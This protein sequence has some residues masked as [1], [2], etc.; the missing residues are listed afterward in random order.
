[1]TRTRTPFTNDAEPP[2]KTTKQR[3]LG[4][5]PGWVESPAREVRTRSGLYVAVSLINVKRFCK[6]NSY[7][8]LA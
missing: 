5:I 6:T 1:M 7:A 3:S 2:D 8:F 4:W